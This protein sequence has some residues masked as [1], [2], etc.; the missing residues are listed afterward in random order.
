MW[1]LQWRHNE[2]SGI[3]NHWLLHCLLNPLSAR[4]LKKAAKLSVTCLCEGNSPRTS[5]FPSQRASNTENVSIW[6]C[7]HDSD[8]IWDVLNQE[9]NVAELIA[10]NSAMWNLTDLIN[11]ISLLYTIEGMIYYVQFL[12]MIK[13]KWMHSSLITMFETHNHWYSL[14]YSL[15]IEEWTYTWRE[16]YEWLI[17]IYIYSIV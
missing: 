10:W 14:F 15:V 16:S 11:Y 1:S 5:E 8:K 3:S 17:Y 2:H 6:W 7:C 12:I 13:E 9:A 4:R